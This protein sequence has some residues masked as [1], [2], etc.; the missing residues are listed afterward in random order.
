MN[1]PKLRNKYTPLNSTNFGTQAGKF[2]A[3]S[4]VKVYFPSPVLNAKKILT[5]KCHVDDST[6]GRYDI[7]IVRRIYI[8]TSTNT[9]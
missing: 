1:D 2:T 3:N 7:I 6:A 5:W 8:K 4:I 9:I